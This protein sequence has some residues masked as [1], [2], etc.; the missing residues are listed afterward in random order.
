LKLVTTAL[1]VDGYRV[2]QAASGPEA[3]ELA[4]TS[5]ASIDLIV[6]DAMMPT[7]GGVELAQKLLAS[8]PGLAVIV[9]SGYTHDLS[10]IQATGRSISTLQKPFTPME[11]RAKVR[12]ALRSNES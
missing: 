11:L 1:G 7:M 6:T 10:S 9:M 12:N 4:N 5:E 8:R 2:L 3:L